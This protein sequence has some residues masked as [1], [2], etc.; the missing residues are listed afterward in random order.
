MPE[1]T[2]STEFPSGPRWQQD[3][4]LSLS[5]SNR[6]ITHLPQLSEEGEWKSNEIRLAPHRFGALT[7]ITIIFIP[8]KKRDKLDKLDRPSEIYLSPCFMHVMVGFLLST[9]LTPRYCNVLKRARAGERWLS[10][11]PL[12]KILA[13]SP[14]LKKCNNSN[15]CFC[16][17]KC[18]Q[19]P[20]AKSHVRGK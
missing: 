13:W 4:I 2:G 10:N 18:F 8:E 6:K 5:L 7:L 20:A 1:L 14:S 15:L 3:P 11:D 16:R 12:V 9:F 19:F 17:R